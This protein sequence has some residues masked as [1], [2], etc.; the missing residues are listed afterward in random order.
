[1]SISRLHSFYIFIASTPKRTTKSKKRK[2]DKK[3]TPQT[4]QT[5]VADTSYESVAD[6][7]DVEEE[8][9]VESV[10]SKTKPGPEMSAAEKLKSQTQTSP[11]KTAASSASKTTKRKRHRR[12]SGT[13]SEE[14][15]WLDAI[16]SGKLEQVD[17]ELK[18]IKDPR[19]MTAR[20]R[21]IYDRTMDNK[22]SSN[23]ASEALL[24]LPSGYKEKVMTAEAIQKAQLKSQKRKQMADEKREKDKKKTMDRLLKKQE[25]KVTKASKKSTAKTTK[26][27][28]SYCDSTANGA[29]LRYPPN[30]EFPLA[31]QR[32]VPP[33]KPK[34]CIVCKKVKRYNCSK[35][36]KPLCSLKCY[37]INVKSFKHIFK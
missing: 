31:A 25:S 34:L 3:E 23:A 8:V 37:K 33:P 17:D 22:E 26:P 19:L 7:I 5:P 28:I 4:P 36:N 20:Q 9:V 14:E 6:I 35:T 21:A 10:P 2:I 24:A 11:A 13:S 16:E 1:M 30:V 32:K 29:T 27:V 18:K 15:R 12:G